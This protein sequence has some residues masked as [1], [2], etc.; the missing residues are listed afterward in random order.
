M[1][2]N[3][4]VPRDTA[5]LLRGSPTLDCSNLGLLLARYVPRE[6]IERTP[7]PNDRYTLWRDKWLKDVCNQLD[8]GKLEAVAAG[9]LNRWLAMTEGTSR[10][11]MIAQGRLIVGLGG[12]G[13]L[14]FG[15]TL[16]HTT[17]MP[18]IPGSALKGLCRNYALLTLADEAKVDTSSEAALSTFEADLFKE[19]AQAKPASNQ[20]LHHAFCAIFGSQEEAGACVFYDG[21]LSEFPNGTLFTVDVMTPHFSQY[22]RTSGGEAPHDGDSPIPVSFLTVREGTRFAFAVGLRR[23][24]NDDNLRKQARR[25]LRAAL[26]E[27]GIGAKTAAGYGVFMPV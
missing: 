11:E 18:F 27:L 4:L 8:R 2:V 5:A 25:W 14:E 20:N 22:Y 9:M 19:Y 7:L 6:A 16:H 17:G 13:V 10:T 3:Y 1:A 23:E 12:K 24:I 21:V 26:Y 15:I